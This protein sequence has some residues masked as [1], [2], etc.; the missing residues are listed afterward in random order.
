M[1]NSYYIS[2]LEISQQL[3]V[4]EDSFISFLQ[5]KSC[6]IVFLKSLEEKMI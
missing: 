2:L 5:K 6:I 3:S 4:M 1:N